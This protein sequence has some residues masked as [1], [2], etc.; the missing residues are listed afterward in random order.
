MQFF[1]SP[2]PTTPP[3]GEEMSAAVKLLV[4]IA[5]VIV[6]EVFYHSIIN[7]IAEAAKI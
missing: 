2:P 5:L 7:A 6:A 4:G 3:D 1:V